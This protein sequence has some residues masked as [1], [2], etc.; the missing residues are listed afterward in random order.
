MEDDSAL[1]AQYDDERIAHEIETLYR[2]VLSFR[3]FLFEL[4]PAQREWM[5]AGLP[6]RDEA[7]DIWIDFEAWV[8]T[9]V[10]SLRDPMETQQAH[11]G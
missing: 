4:T 11:D 3:S 10:R 6:W 7:S 9:T 1:C 5:A 8:L 2:G